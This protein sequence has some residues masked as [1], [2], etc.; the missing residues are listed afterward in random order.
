[1]SIHPSAI[2]DEAARIGADVTIGPWC[3][4]GPDVVLGDGVQLISH[5]VIT[6]HT[7]IGANS[8]VHPL[9]SWAGILSIWHMTKAL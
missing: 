6:G 9:R 3:V 7:E 1:M 2:V 5:V 4:V 8:V